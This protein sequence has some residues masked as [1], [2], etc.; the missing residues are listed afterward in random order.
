M[1]L[2]PSLRANRAVAIASNAVTAAIVV[3]ALYFAREV[4]VPIVLAGLLS[5]ILTPPMLRLQ[6]LGLGRVAAVAAVTL[7]S[8]AVLAALGVVMTGQFAQFVDDLPRY[9]MN[10]EG[11]V[12]SLQEKATSG[13]IVQSVERVLE[14]LREPLQRGPAATGAD[15]APALATPAQPPPTVVMRPPATTPFVIASELLSPLVAP[16]ATAGIV[17]VFVVFILLQR[18]DLRDRLI[19]LA[20]ARDLR[21]TTIALDEAG[22]RL[23]RYFLALT[24]INATFGLL[25]GVGLWLIGIPNFVLWGLLAMMLRFLP[26]IG[27]P[28]SAV[29]PMISGDRHRPWLVEGVG[30]RRALCRP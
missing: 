8:F 28:L 15:P 20:G 9:E 19:W 24:A 17:V 7:I 14:R 13:P 2:H 27:G 30:D 6:N 12:K 21:R 1:S 22:S 26:Y 18:E 11:K 29:F 23:S 3:A 10:L 25:V 4:L 16:I 5:F